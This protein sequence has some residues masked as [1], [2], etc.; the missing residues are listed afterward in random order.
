MIRKLIWTLAALM[1]MAGPAAAQA[2]APQATKKPTTAAS[3]H[4]PV[5]RVPR[6][7]LPA[8]PELP[9]LPAL[10]AMPE[11]PD[12][13][14]LS[15]LSELS[16]LSALS[17]LAAMPALQLSN[18]E[19][20][21][22]FAQEQSERSRE[23]A[24]RAKE[25]AERDRER[26]EEMKDREQER[27]DREE[28]L[29]DD[30]TE[31]LD[32]G[33][34]EKAAQR[35]AQVAEMKGKKADAA[36]YWKGY[37]EYKG[38]HREAAIATLAELQKNYPKSNYVKDAKALEI[39]VRSGRQVG[40]G[41]GGPA[42]GPV[43]GPV[44]RSTGTSEEDCELK[45]L[46]INSLMHRDSEQAVPLLE[47]LLQSGIANCP[48]ARKQALFVL[49]QSGSPRAREVME[50]VARGQLAPDLQRDA[51]NNLGIFGG[52]ESRA[53]LKSIYEASSDTSIK[54][55]ILQ[56]FMVSGEKEFLLGVARNEKDPDLRAAAV[57]QLG[58]MGAK[59][60]LWQMYQQETTTEVK[61][62]IIGGMF[63]GGDAEHMILLAK[64]EKD[65]DLR[66]KA[67]N[68]LGLMGSKRTGD[69]LVELYSSEKETG[70][71]KSVLNAFFLQGNCRQLVDVA[72]KETDQELKRSAVQKLS[73]MSCKEGTDFLMELLNKP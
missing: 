19:L 21:G 18:L 1:L 59:D 54:K 48:K 58:V 33:Q 16:N 22:E 71:R 60:E 63:V 64:S 62:K 15:A 50:K 40:G 57:Q 20:S 14:G 7:A 46:A 6:I 56:S 47:T 25:K 68:N 4:A 44:G 65:P 8:L 35:F 36:L 24:E 2:A 73:L 27:L 12:L 67:I 53:V 30:G 3:K 38:G 28:E 52:H 51:I 32:E 43:G 5:V 17:A 39:E 45:L 70:V 11:L 31:Y 41:I 61:S 26:A 10:A 72:R 37:A 13:S 66:K 42:G 29:Y 34:W 9:E 55:K 49:A 23:Q 69:A